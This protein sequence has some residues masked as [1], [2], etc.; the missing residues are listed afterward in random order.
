MIHHTG[1]RLCASGSMLTRLPLQPLIN[2]HTVNIPMSV[3]HI[4]VPRRHDNTQP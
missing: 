1:T 2:G 3:R 4:Q